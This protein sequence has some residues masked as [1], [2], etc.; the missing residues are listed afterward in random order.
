MIHLVTD[1]LGLVISDLPFPIEGGGD[2][3]TFLSQSD[4]M[5][6]YLV[7]GAQWSLAHGLL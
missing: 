2:R 6:E 4:L 5:E 1:P 7:H 3:E